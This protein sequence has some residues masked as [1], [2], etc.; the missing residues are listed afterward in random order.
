MIRTTSAA[1]VL[2]ASTLAWASESVT[3]T[4]ILDNTLIQDPG[5]TYS[6]GKAANFYAGRVG[7]N[8]GGT[9]RRGVLKFDLSAIP[10]GSSIE[11]ATI[12]LYCSKAGLGTQFPVS[13]KRLTA[14]FGEGASVAF[15]GGGATAEPGDA[16]WQHRFYPDVPWSSPGGDFVG[17]VSA[18]RNV[19]GIGFYT[20][21]STAELVA[22]VQEWI[23]DP[24]GH[25]GWI[26]QGNETTLQSVKRFDSRESSPS[27]RP[28]LVVVFQPPASTPGDLNGDRR[29]DAVDLSILLGQWGGS[30]IADLDGSGLVG[31]ADLAILLG[32]WTG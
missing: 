14:S 20:W 25:H 16:T 13:F 15:G 17:T 11:S 28:K 27:V 30:G 4:T 18:V 10:A 7:T 9:I 29:V 8:G 21:N 24:S 32:G 2:A 22:D 3:V 26:V 1:L 6:A 31:A 19:G 12:T 5:G 23:D